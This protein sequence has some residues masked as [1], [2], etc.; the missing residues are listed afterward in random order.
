MTRKLS[1]ADR[2]A[3]FSGRYGHEVTNALQNQE[4]H[5][6]EAAA[7]A[8]RNFDSLDTDA[9]RAAADASLVTTSG[10]KHMALMFSQAAD[11]AAQACEEW[12]KLTDPEEE[13]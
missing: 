9:K 7:E 8:Q 13:D 6:R 2:L 3:E 5:M 11:S 1:T 12:E 10:W 4:R